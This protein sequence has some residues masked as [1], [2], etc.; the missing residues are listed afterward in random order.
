MPDAP[1]PTSPANAAHHPDLGEQHDVTEIHAALLREPAEVALHAAL[2]D[3]VPEAD[4]AFV[5]GDYTGS[6]LAI[7]VLMPP[8]WTTVTPTVLPSNS[9][10][11]D[12]LK[13]R[14]AN[15]AEA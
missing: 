4:A 9:W 7:S 5:T 2:V 12:S 14:T 8:G 3:V 1:S 13:P 10:R 15:F 6:L 11:N